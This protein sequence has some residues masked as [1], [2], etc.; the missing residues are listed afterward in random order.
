V[1]EEGRFRPTG[2]DLQ[3]MGVYRSDGTRKGDLIGTPPI[4]FIVSMSP[5]GYPSAELRP[6]RARF[7]FA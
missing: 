1:V 7:R 2:G 4:C 6:R 5:S 3:G